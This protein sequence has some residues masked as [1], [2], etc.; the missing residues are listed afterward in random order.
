[1]APVSP[2]KITIE[3]ETESDYERITRV[4]A[5]AFNGNAEARLVEN[6]RKTTEYIPQLSLVAKHKNKI[7]GHVLFY[8]IKINTGR[9]ECISLALARFLSSPIFK[10][11]KV[12]VD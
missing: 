8:P 7:I 9:E 6:L 2:M 1:L 12:E 11:E 10:T 3:P 5:L 4:T